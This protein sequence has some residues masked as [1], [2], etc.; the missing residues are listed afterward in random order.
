MLLRLPFRASQISDNNEILTGQAFGIGRNGICPCLALGSAACP[1]FGVSR[2][3]SL[4]RESF[5][6]RD[7]T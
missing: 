1:T 7:T 5:L 4:A 2:S 3:L 6:T